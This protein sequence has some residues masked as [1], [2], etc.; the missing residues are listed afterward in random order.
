MNCRLPYYV[1]SVS[2]VVGFGATALLPAR[3][4]CSSTLS[5]ST[6]CL[7]DPIVCSLRAPCETV[8]P[9]LKVNGKNVDATYSKYN[10]GTAVTVR[11]NYCALVSSVI[12]VEIAS[13]EENCTFVATHTAG[14]SAQ[15][16]YPLLLQIAA[17]AAG[18]IALKGGETFRF[19]YLVSALSAVSSIS[20]ATF[21]HPAIKVLNVS[22]SVPSDLTNGTLNAFYNLTTDTDET[23][24]ASPLFHLKNV[25]AGVIVEVNVT[26]YLRRYVR[27]GAKLNFDLFAA[28]S[29]SNATLVK[30]V[31]DSSYVAAL[32]FA[33]DFTLKLP[34]HASADYTQ[35]KWV[36]PT[37]DG[38]LFSSEIS[39][40]VPCVTADLSVTI[41]V[42]NYYTWENMI[43]C[44]ALNITDFRVTRLPY[45]LT[46][47]SALCP[48]SS[49]PYGNGVTRSNI[50]YKFAYNPL[51]TVLTASIG[52]IQYRETAAAGSNSGNCTDADIRIALAGRVDIQPSCRY[53]ICDILREDNITVLVDFMQ[54]NTLPNWAAWAAPL[55]LQ[56]QNYTNFKISIGKPE[57]GLFIYPSAWWGDAGDSLVLTF[58]VAPLQWYSVYKANVTFWIDERFVASEVAELCLYNGTAGGPFCSMVLFQHQRIHLYFEK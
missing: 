34:L 45:D 2:L 15:C 39:V 14:V 49:C 21:A 29:Y 7:G 17:P 37:N 52:P 27:A 51:N 57:V 53:N 8:N 24:Q 43:P 40:N 12:A 13:G 44:I 48:Y 41:L 22:A 54:E 4:N 25:T 33:H 11:T 36:I 28:Y 3:L 6:V 19:R 47:V 56:S 1:I 30:T 23:K 18:T 10:N 58:G 46:L 16:R 50:N 32:P 55:M 9:S 31:R 20:L 42:P 5:T 38:D 26:A 35:L